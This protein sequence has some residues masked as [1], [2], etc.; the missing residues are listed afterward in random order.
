MIPIKKNNN[1][2]KVNL[3]NEDNLSKEIYMIIKKV[4]ITMIQIMYLLQIIK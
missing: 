3:N 4:E 2:F 1:K